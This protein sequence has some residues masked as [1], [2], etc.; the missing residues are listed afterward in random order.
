MWRAHNR[1]YILQTRKEK[2]AYLRAMRDDYMK[3][4]RDRPFKIQGYTVMS[5]HAHLNGQ[6]GD[7]S[8]PLSDHMRRAHS[9][10]GM[11]YNKRH[12]RLGKVAHD[13][14]KIKTSQDETY[15]MEVMLYDHCNPVRAK[16]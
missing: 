16:T 6:N 4:C 8:K 15:S 7:N 11:G 14:P 13:R 12:D 10:F 3:N 5:N 1:E 9:R 2:L